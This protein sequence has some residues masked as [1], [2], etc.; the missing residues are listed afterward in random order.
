M[1]MVSKYLVKKVA[2]S[3]FLPAFYLITAKKHWFFQLNNHC[4]SPSL[5]GIINDESIKFI[6]NVAL[7]CLELLFQLADEIFPINRFILLKVSKRRRIF[8][9]ILFIYILCFIDSLKIFQHWCIYICFEMSI[10]SHKWSIILLSLNA[11]F[12]LQ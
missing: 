9:I 7:L 1:I 10:F 8:Y 5:E 12:E 4:I 2:V 11:Y 3:L 6:L